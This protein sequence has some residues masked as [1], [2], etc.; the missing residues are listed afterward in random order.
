M[1]DSE[2]QPITFSVAKFFSSSLA[3]FIKL[4][5]ETVLRRGQVAVLSTPSYVRA[6]DS[7]AGKGKKV[8][9]AAT[10]LETIIPPGRYDGVVGTLYTIV[11]EEG[12]RPVPNKATKDKASAAKKGKERIVETVYRR[13][14]GLDGL[15]RGW[16]VSW[17]GLVG[18]W[19]AGVVNSGGNGEF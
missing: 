5:I 13:G 15:W 11:S 9:A 2:L 8:T 14:Q 1:I 19:A 10:E 17:W 7:P 18:L 4:P 6:L 3:L 16:K 12:S